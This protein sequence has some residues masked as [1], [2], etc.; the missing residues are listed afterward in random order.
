MN[1]LI[2]FISILIGS[3]LSFLILNKILK[4]YYEFISFL[5]FLLVLSVGTLFYL[6]VDF[7]ISNNI[8]FLFFSIIV[9]YLYYSMKHPSNSLLFRGNENKIERIADSIC[10]HKKSLF[11]RIKSDSHLNDYFYLKLEY[12][13]GNVKNKN[14]QE[15]YKS[16]YRMHLFGFTSEFYEKYFKLLEKGETDLKKILEEL[17]K[18]KNESGKKTV[19]LAFASKLIHMVDNERPLYNSTVSNIFNINVRRGS[20]KVRIKSSL[21][22]YQEL[23]KNY[24]K[25]LKNE[26]VEEAINN[27]RGKFNFQE[28]VLSDYK[29]LDLILHKLKKI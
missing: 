20:I 18:I 9:F 12:E 8:Y 26:K 21:E 16:F 24:Q 23:E 19:Q 29:L 17:S 6:L 1:T 27:F 28:G 5:T 13:K 4:A 2:I 15:R 10:V 3:F 7:S 22:A 11:Q 25:L 14:F